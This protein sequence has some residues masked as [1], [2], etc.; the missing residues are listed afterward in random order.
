MSKKTWSITGIIFGVVIVSLI[1]YSIGITSAQTEIDEETYDYEGVVLKISEAETTL[2]DIKKEISDKE[3]ERTKKDQI[4]KDKEKEVSKAF[5]ILKK[6]DALK[7]DLDKLS[8]KMDEAKKEKS[9]LDTQIK[10]KK[11]E[12]A[13]L[14]NVIK[15][16]EAVPIT[17]TAGQFLAGHDFKAGRYKAVPEGGGGNFVVY[18]DQGDLSVNII[19]TTRDYGVPEYVMTL[20]DGYIIEA[21]TPAKLIPV[22]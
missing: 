9:S 11:A 17:L 19:L 5:S 6:R 14:E 15:E 7:K 1:S 21:D 10:D 16:K 13:S 2:E 22:E 4:L 8:G 12:L 18:T 20:G 3:S